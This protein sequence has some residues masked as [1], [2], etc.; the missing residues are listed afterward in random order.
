MIGKSAITAFCLALTACAS[1]PPTVAVRVVCPP[2]SVWTAPQ[3]TELA[4]ALSHVSTESAIWTM[5][6][7]WQATRDAIRACQAGVK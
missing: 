7:D 3:Q 5:E 6:K 4:D 1:T 2:L